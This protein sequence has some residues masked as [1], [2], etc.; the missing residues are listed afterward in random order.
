L[1][2]ILP[3]RPTFEDDGTVYT[4]EVDTYDDTGTY[5]TNFD[6]RISSIC[7]VEIDIMWNAT[8]CKEISNALFYFMSLVM[9]VTTLSIH[10][11]MVRSFTR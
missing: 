8:Y 4:G 7:V 10:V 3:I 9:S 6:Q 1:N 11:I 2:S 5:E